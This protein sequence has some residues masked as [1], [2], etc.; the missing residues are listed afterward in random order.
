MKAIIVAD[1][2]VPQTADALDGLLAPDQDGSIVVIAADG[3]ARK[4]ADLGL[5]PDLV[6]GDGDSLGREDID[7]LRESGVE[8]QLLPA[9]KD[10]SDTELAV[11]EALARGAR[12]IV[13][14]GAFGGRRLDHTLANVALLALPELAGRD[15][16]LWDGR[17]RARLIGRADGPG[18]IRV[19]GERGDLVSLFP[20]DPRVDGVTTDGLRYPLRGEA[21]V[22]GPSRGLSNE[23]VDASGGIT[24]ARGRLLVVHTTRRPA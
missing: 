13:V 21:L 1:G 3:G 9:E 17:A 8:V 2:E 22:V 11:R 10:E 19:A 20:V 12:T 14:L 18:A 24:T 23:L 7:R 15:M 5:T 4:A 16:S 6:I